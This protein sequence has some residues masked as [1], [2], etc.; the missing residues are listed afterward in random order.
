MYPST[1]INSSRGLLVSIPLAHW[2]HRLFRCL[3]CMKRV[4][5]MNMADD[6]SRTWYRTECWSHFSNFKWYSSFVWSQVVFVE[7]NCEPARDVPSLLTPKKL[8]AELR[9][10]FS[11]HVIQATLWSPVEILIWKHCAQTSHNAFASL[12]TII[13]C[14]SNHHIFS[15]DTFWPVLIKFNSDEHKTKI[16]HGTW[17]LLCPIENHDRGEQYRHRPRH[18]PTSP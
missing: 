11:S 13:T 7:K 6:C 1:N 15:H 9:V 10:T 12:N 17:Q 16:K 18:S 2:S 3:V 8:H 14:S 5:C 4:F